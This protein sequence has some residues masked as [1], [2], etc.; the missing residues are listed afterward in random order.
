MD[1]KIEIKYE[2]IATFGI[3]TKMEWEYNTLQEAKTQYELVKKYKGLKEIK[4]NQIKIEKVNL[5]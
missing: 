1:K 5:F 3:G 4:C 2:I